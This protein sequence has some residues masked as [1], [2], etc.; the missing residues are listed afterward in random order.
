ML[1]QRNVESPKVRRPP[2]IPIAPVAPPELLYPSFLRAINQS[3]KVVVE[4]KLVYMYEGHTSQQTYAS[5][6]IEANDASKRRYHGLERLAG[7]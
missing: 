6:V 2:P 3:T 7:Q 4:L 1:I 5:D